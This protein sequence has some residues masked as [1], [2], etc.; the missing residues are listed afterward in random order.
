MPSPKGYKQFV[1]EVIRNKLP[2]TCSDSKMFIADA[3]KVSLDIS[4]PDEASVM[5]IDDNNVEKANVTRYIGVILHFERQDIVWQGLVLRSC[6]ES[7]PTSRT[8]V[9]PH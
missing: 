3:S 5:H 2:T 9:D 4:V 7:T 6:Y 8:G 1:G